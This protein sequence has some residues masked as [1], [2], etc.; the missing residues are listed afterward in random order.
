ME[1]KNVLKFETSVG[2]MVAQYCDD[3]GMTF[4][5]G[6]AFAEQVQEEVELLVEGR[7]DNPAV[8]VEHA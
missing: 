5:E 6:M 2:I 1:H 8:V 3:N 4:E 7:R